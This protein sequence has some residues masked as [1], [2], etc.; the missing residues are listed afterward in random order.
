MK[1]ATLH[2][3]ER[4]LMGQTNLVLKTIVSDCN[5]IYSYLS[6]YSDIGMKT[7]P[8]LG[9]ISVDQTVNRLDYAVYGFAC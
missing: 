8:C 2:R 6:I 5:Q 1:K 3:N 4:G 9:L 7:L